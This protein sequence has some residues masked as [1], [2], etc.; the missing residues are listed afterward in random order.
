MTPA[1]WIKVAR[2]TDLYVGLHYSRGRRW[3]NSPV[4]PEIPDIP[5]GMGKEI[6]DLLEAEMHQSQTKDN[7]T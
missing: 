7:P 1:D 5:Q 4:G 3:L 2:A 6:A